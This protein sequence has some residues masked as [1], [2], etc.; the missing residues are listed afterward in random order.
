MGDVGQGFGG[1]NKCQNI[2]SSGSGK[3]MQI[4]SLNMTFFIFIITLTCM[5]LVGLLYENCPP[6]FLSRSLE[7]LC[8]VSFIDWFL[9][10]YFTFFIFHHS[11]LKSFLG[12]FVVS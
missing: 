7:I 1:W 3:L 11:F 10:C 12:L 6:R 4:V 9:H 5:C 2:A 8:P